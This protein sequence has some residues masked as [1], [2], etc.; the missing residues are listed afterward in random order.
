LHSKEFDMKSFDLDSDDDNDMQNVELHT[1]KQK[2]QPQAATTTEL[3]KEKEPTD[4]NNIS[5]YQESSKQYSMKPKAKMLP[6][7]KIR[8][9]S[10]YSTC[11]AYITPI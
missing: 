8:P 11:T 10:K 3:E 4:E 6:M 7:D 5:L 9:T 2:P 1:V